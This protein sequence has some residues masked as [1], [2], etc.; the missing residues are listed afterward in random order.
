L[1]CHRIY[2][3]KDKETEKTCHH[4]NMAVIYKLHPVWFHQFGAI[5]GDEV[6]GFKSKSLSSIMNKAKNAEYRWGT[7][8][9]LDGTQVHKLVLE[10]L[11]GPVNRK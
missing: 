2:S 11:F 9:T 3:G 10:G 8:G 4:I 7:T 6:H 1:N 5:F